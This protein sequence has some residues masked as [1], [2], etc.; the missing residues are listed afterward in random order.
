MSLFVISV[1]G[2]EEYRPIWFRKEFCLTAEF[3][4]FVHKAV[5]QAVKKLDKREPR[6]YIRGNDILD[7]IVPLM[8]KMG[9]EVVRPELE[10]DLRGEC[11]YGDKEED[12]PDII[13]AET[14]DLI[15]EHNK[16][17]HN[18]LYDDRKKRHSKPD[19]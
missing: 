14:W 18:Y 8:K 12:R 10:I 19:K 9:F 17:V 3:T 2:Y 7:V 15:V 16:K 13:D 1:S 6:D 11:L 5:I 4:E